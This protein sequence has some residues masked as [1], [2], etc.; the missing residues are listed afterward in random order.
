M[1]PKIPDQDAASSLVILLSAK[2]QRQIEV[3]KSCRPSGMSDTAGFDERKTAKSVTIFV[4]IFDFQTLPTRVWD[5]DGPCPPRKLFGLV[6]ELAVE[7]GHYPKKTGPDPARLF[8]EKS[9]PHTCRTVPCSMTSDWSFPLLN[10]F[11]LRGR[12]ELTWLIDTN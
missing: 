4:S 7:L 12:T 8:R 5:L 11:R 1:N 6:S 10:D 3:W 9:F 2:R